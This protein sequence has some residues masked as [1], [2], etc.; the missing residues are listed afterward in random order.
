MREGLECAR[1]LAVLARPVQRVG[2]GLPAFV[3]LTQRDR[4][5][6]RAVEVAVGAA[7][8][9]VDD[10]A[11][12]EVVEK[13]GQAQRV[14]AAG[15]DRRR[16]LHAEPLLEIHRALALVALDHVGDDA[17]VAFAFHLAVAHGADVDARGPLQT[18]HLGQHERGVAAFRRRRGD[19][20]VAGAVVVQV[21]VRIL[22]ACGR[23]H[24][25]SADVAVDQE[26][27]LVGVGAEGL[28]REVGSRAHFVV[29]VGG[30][31]HREQLGLAGFVLRT[32]Q[33][34]VDQ[35][36]GLLDRREYLVALRLVVLDEIATEP[37]LVR[38]VGERLRAQTQLGLD[39]R[40]GDVAA[41]AHRAAEDAPQVGNVLGRAVE[42]LDHT[43]GHVEVDHLRVRDVAHALVVADGQRQEGHQHEAAVDHVAVEQLDRVG[44]AHVLGRL[45]DVIDERVDAAREVVGG[46][47]FDVGSS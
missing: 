11:V 43:V 38:G 23:H 5:G 14:H 46:R 37:E 6:R 3:G 12:A 40:A 18:R 45:V 41:V 44:D 29:V 34:V 2:A 24:A 7:A 33:G 30:D 17:I 35:R 19:R 10:V 26:G 47:D 28:E 4:A 20:A 36:Q 39:D 42:H 8:G 25:G 21:L 32:L 1:E 31:V 16:R 9:G 13:A 27:E 22:P 15:N